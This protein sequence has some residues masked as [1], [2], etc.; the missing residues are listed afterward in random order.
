[1]P[2]RSASTIVGDG[3]RGR[4]VAHRDRSDLAVSRAPRRPAD[5]AVRPPPWP[6]TT[7]SPRPRPARRGSPRSARP[8][9][10]T[11][12]SASPF[13]RRNGTVD[14]GEAPGT[15]T[16]TRR[17]TPASRAART[18]RTAEPWLASSSASSSGWSGPPTR[19]TSVKTP[20]STSASASASS[21]RSTVTFAPSAR[22]GSADGCVAHGGADLVLAGEQRHQR[23]SDR[24]RGARDHDRH[25]PRCYRPASLSRSTARPDLPARVGICKRSCTCNEL[26][27]SSDGA[28]RTRLRRRDG[29]AARARA[30]DDA[31]ATRHRHRGDANAGAHL[32]RA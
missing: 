14:S 13:A 3:E 28:H 27:P 10:A 26:L 31:A 1:M 20:P 5:P 18:A 8:E 30:S 7:A 19:C 2:A 6:R 15:E 32:A 12:S 16:S 9:V 11:T 25:G 23:V 17:R 4:E 21:S 22:S 24:T 29:S